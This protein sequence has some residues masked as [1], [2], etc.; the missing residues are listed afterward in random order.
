MND[1]HSPLYKIMFKMGVKDRQVQAVLVEEFIL[2]AWTMANKHDMM[3]LNLS[4]KVAV[5]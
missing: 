5:Q 4:I 1:E 3:L 2:R